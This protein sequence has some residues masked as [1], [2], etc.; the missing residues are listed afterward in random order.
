MTKGTLQNH[1]I[2][3]VNAF[4]KRKKKLYK[5]IGISFFANTKIEIDR[6]HFS[7]WFLVLQ[8]YKIKNENDICKRKKKI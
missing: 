3:N 2:K 7:L 8:N 1:K 6:D 4:S 5:K